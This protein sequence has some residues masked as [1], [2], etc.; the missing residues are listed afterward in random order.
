[1][2]GTS[3][4]KPLKVAALNLFYPTTFPLSK[5]PPFSY[6]DTVSDGGGLMW[7]CNG[8]FLPSPSPSPARGEGDNGLSAKRCPIEFYSG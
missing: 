5:N 3:E 8:I 6:C 4:S 2:I 7:G 1:M